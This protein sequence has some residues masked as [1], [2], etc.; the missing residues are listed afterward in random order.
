[1]NRTSFS[2]LAIAALLPM[3]LSMG[4]A[5]AESPVTMNRVEVAGQSNPDIAKLNVASAC[6]GIERAMKAALTPVWSRQGETGLVNVQFRLQGDLVNSIATRGGPESY[7]QPILKAMRHLSC[8]DGSG[9]NQL[10]AFEVQ[11][12]EPS[13]TSGAQTVA[14]LSR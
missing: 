11:F 5:H 9:V 1:M 13:D 4:A 6:P 12:K 2:K 7:R 14:L 10:Y 3:T 8:S